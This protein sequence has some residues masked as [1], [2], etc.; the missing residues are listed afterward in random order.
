[1]YVAEL[2]I[3]ENKIKILRD[4]LGLLQAAFAIPLELSPTHIARFEQGVSEPSQTIID[5]IC[6]RFHVDPRYF[7]TYISGAQLSMQVFLS[8]QVYS[9]LLHFAHHGSEQ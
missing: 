7:V 6:E 1:M 9:V 5:R 4:Y 3:L 2:K 8:T